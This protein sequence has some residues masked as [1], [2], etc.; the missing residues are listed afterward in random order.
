VKLNFLGKTWDMALRNNTGLLVS[1]VVL[2]VLLFI[3][4]TSNLSDHERIVLTPPHMD[5]KWRLHGMRRV[6]S[7]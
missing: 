5:K 4:V 3:S 7:T 6:A 1:N 2:S